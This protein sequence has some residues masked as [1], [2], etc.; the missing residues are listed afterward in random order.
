MQT[1]MAHRRDNAR[2][3]C[4]VKKKRGELTYHMSRGSFFVDSYVFR[5][6]FL[7][8]RLLQRREWSPATQ[9]T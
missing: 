5:S 1:L 3:Y 4:M 2:R 9:R 8:R 6:H 7:S